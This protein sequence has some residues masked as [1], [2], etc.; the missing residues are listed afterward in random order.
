M[1]TVAEFDSLQEGD[2]VEVGALFKGLSK[3][4]VVLRTKARSK[5]GIEIDFVATYLNITLG[6][7][8]ARKSDDRV[9]WTLS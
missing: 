6:K 2:L 5:D 7:W 1:L 9:E 3:D 8:T 4:D